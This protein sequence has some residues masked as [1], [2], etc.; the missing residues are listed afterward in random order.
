MLPDLEL[1]EGWVTVVCLLLMFM[2]V[3]W[4]IQAAHWAEDLA[5]IQGTALVGG[6]MGILLAKSR[7]PNRTSH[8]LSLLA[9]ST[10]AVY[11]T[12]RALAVYSLENR[13]HIFSA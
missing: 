8:F 10:W 12:T 13:F 3:A 1:K 11:L 5:V 9:G 2:C 7:F 4:A 6:I